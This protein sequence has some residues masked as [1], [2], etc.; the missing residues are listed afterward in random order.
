MVQTPG[1]GAYQVPSD[2]GI[3]KTQEKTLRGSESLDKFRKIRAASQGQHKKSE[4]QF[5]T[6]SSQGL[7]DNRNAK[8][9]TAGAAVNIGEIKEEAAK[10]TSN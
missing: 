4:S 10:A 9:T 6:K 1:P 5:S 2:F 8:I 7:P 3:Y